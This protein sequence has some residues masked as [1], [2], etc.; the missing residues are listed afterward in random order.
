[1]TTVI[2]I[3]GVKPADGEITLAVG[4]TVGETPGA[5]VAVGVDGVGK[6]TPVAAW[7]ARITPTRTMAAH[8]KI[9]TVHV[10]LSGRIFFIETVSPFTE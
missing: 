7:P 1:V 10:R 2:S 3:T 8:R 9:R 4:D 6:V 5:T